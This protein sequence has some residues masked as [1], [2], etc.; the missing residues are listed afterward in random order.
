MTRRKKLIEVA[1]PLK[2]I[3]EASAREKSIRH[4]HPSTLH[5][6]WAR[7]PLA[8]CRAVL[9][10]SL[11][12]DPDSDPMYAG[13]GEEI[14]GAKRAELFNLIEELVQWENS[15]NP[16]VINRARAEIAR[17]I[18]ANK[19]ADGDWKNEAV[20]SLSDRSPAD[21]SANTDTAKFG[22]T[23]T[24]SVRDVKNMLAQ[25]EAVNAFLA[26]H[27]PPVLDPFC[28]GGSIPLEAQR[29]GLRACASDLNPVPVLITKAL[30]EIPP[31]FAARP[32][33]NPEWRRKS[34]EE[35]AAHVW[36]G[37]QGLA[38]DV[39]Y[40]G[41][42][43]RDEAFRRIG[44]LYP[45]VKITVDMG[46]RRPDL[47]EYVG[48]E[49]TVI[50]WIWARTVPSPNPACR[51][52]RVPLARSFWLATKKGKEAYL[53]PMV[54]RANNRYR[55]AVRTGQPP[56]KSD[57]DA[58]T[59]LG[60]G[61]KFRCILSDQP[62]PESDIKEA[63]KKGELGM[64]LLAVVAE[65]RN[66]RVY[67]EADCTTNEDVERPENL[68]GIDAPLAEDPRNLWCL[69][70]GFDTF[71]KLFTNRQLVSMTCLSDLVVESH[72]RIASDATA[73]TSIK[74]GPHSSLETL[75]KPLARHL[76]PA[77]P[78]S[79]STLGGDKSW[80]VLRCRRS[81][82]KNWKRICR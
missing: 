24:V 79:S 78:E 68:E 37:A 27:A 28:G 15:N 30:I 2:A 45:K 20:L 12:D 5:L 46:K 72:S 26:E 56:N 66:S 14:A 82:W 74:S 31:N 43:M 22:S 40:Y 58:G 67:L 47:K 60:R 63:G 55:F 25:P 8:A 70:Y 54:D 36:R 62:I 57:I 69:G 61:C 73:V 13:A 11:V 48:Q 77:S 52:A 50:A 51:G 42:W 19:V 33:V 71:D 44:H 32:P 1:L 76:R 81:L 7:R 59:K 65:G 41:R 49:L 17:S 21:V 9:F 16:H 39:R 4:G 38:E 53:E 6:W 34:A 3:N 35:K 10:A 64:V 29:L 18:A 75:T 80:H 23:I